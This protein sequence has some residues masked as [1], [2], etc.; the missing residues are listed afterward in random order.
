MPPCHPFLLPALFALNKAATSRSARSTAGGRCWPFIRR[1]E[2][3]QEQ[4]VQ[5]QVWG[6]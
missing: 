1:E 3:P 5:E 4:A 2:G 6:S